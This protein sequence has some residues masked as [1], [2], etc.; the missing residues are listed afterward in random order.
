MIVIGGSIRI[1]PAKLDEAV[2]VAQKMMAETKQ[3]PGCVQYNFS[4]DLADKGLVWIFEEWE[5]ED[6]LSK[7][8]ETPHMAEFMQAMPA[9]GLQ[10]MDVN[11]YEASAKGPVM[12]SS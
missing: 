9:F 12:P 2:G 10:V 3:E 6:A 4:L 8:F 7:H 1:D 11:R 5:S